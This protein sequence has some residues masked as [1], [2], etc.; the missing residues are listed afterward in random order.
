M[1]TTYHPGQ[2]VQW[3]ELLAGKPYITYE[4]V[5]KAISQNMQLAFIE[6]TWPP[7]TKRYTH[8]P[9]NRLRVKETV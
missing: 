6:Q 1:N 2:A 3:D 4:G 8:V 5:L 9:L 7:S